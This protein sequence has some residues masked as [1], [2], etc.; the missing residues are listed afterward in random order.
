MKKLLF[1]TLVFALLLIAGC[2]QE[3]SEEI[4]G[5]HVAV[6]RQVATAPQE[7]SAPEEIAEEAVPEEPADTT[8]EKYYCTAEERNTKTCI[9]IELPVC[10]D[11]GETYVNGCLACM[12]N[13]VTYI[14]KGV[15]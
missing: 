13:S 9:R 5:N 2:G 15:C 4:N 11:N 8:A 10:A 7:P 14:T 6:P 12:D 1:V 3:K